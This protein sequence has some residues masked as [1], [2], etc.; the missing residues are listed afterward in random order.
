MT[1]FSPRTARAAVV[2]FS[3]CPA[4]KIN[5]L[6]NTWDATPILNEKIC[7][8]ILAYVLIGVATSAAPLAASVADS[9]EEKVE[10]AQLMI[11][12]RV[13]VRV[14]AMRLQ[15]APVPMPQPIPL[16]EV[17]GPKCLVMSQLAGAAI[18]RPDS[19]DLYLRGGRRLRAQL[20]DDCPALDYYSGFYLAPTKD[21]QVCGGRDTIHARSGGK[22]LID[23]FRELVPKR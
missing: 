15:A 19:V 16:K 9:A 2:I 17:K 18:T 1:P 4:P 13:V 14:P 3:T 20:D 8:T 5:R 6:F 12:R 21:G 22:C 10:F 23:R 11:Q 7:V